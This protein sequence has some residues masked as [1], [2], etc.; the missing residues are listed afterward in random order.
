[1]TTASEALVK[2]LWQKIWIEGDLDQ[3]DEL[4]APQFVRH[5]RDGT[6]TMTPSEYRRH[7]SSVVRTIRGTEVT[8]AH[9]ASCDDMVFARLNLHG[10]N[11]D[12][13]R[14]V[15]LTWMTQYRIAGERIA[16]AWTMHQ[17]DLDW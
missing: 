4:L 10:V 9:I 1:M 11:L 14:D 3:V 7:I 12:T 2:S 17:P 8:I 15:K 16:E 5:T 6:T 13:S